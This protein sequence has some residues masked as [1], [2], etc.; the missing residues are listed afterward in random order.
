[1]RRPRAMLAS[2]EE[3]RARQTMSVGGASDRDASGDDRAAGARF[4]L[5]A[6]DDRDPR[7]ERPHRMSKGGAVGV[8]QAPV[9]HA[10][11][12]HVFAKA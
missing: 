10:R 7:G 5:A 12:P 11:A 6:G 9:A 2:V 3:E 1:M 4:A 8:A